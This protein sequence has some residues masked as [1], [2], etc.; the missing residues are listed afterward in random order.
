M[1]FVRR[2]PERTHAPQR[3]PYARQADADQRLHHNF[4]QRILP[5]RKW[6]I[7]HYDLS[8]V[9]LGQNLGAASYAEWKQFWL[10][11]QDF[12]DLMSLHHVD[13]DLHFYLNASAFRSDAES[14]RTALRNAKLFEAVISDQEIATRA[15]RAA[16]TSRFAGDL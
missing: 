10:D 16:D 11:L 9:R 4:R 1:S 6:F 3:T 12:L 15:L 13:P 2:P 8:A 14:L 5:A 7:A